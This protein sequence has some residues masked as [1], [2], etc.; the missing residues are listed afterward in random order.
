MFHSLIVKEPK[1]VSLIAPTSN[2]VVNSVA[3]NDISKCYVLSTPCL[4]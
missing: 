2:N 3:K 4:S 1:F